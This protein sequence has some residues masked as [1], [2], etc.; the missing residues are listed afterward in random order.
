MNGIL[1]EAVNLKL[2][3]NLQMSRQVSYVK[4]VENILIS[5]NNDFIPSLYER[6]EYNGTLKDKVSFM[7]SEKLA[8]GYHYILALDEADKV[9]GFTDIKEESSLVYG[10]LLKTIAIGTSA[11]QKEFQGKGIAKLLYSFV[12]ELAIQLDVDVVTRRTWSSN[13]R[14]LNLYERF[15]YKQV[16]CVLNFRGEGI[17]ALYFCKWFKDACVIQ[18]NSI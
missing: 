3:S 4:D 9:I 17:H 11:I 14:Q 5:N 18:A 8:E 6:I 10:E 15:G 1:R 12:D 7:V 2:V 13:I 16:E